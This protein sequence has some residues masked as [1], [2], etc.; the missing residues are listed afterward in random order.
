MDPLTHAV[1][2]ASFALLISKP[3]QK[4]WALLC[5]LIAGTIPDLD[6]LI[7]SKENPLL[8][9]QYHRHFTHSLFF[10]PFGALIASWIVL[11]FARHKIC[12]KE[13]YRYCFI[14]YLT[15]PLLDAATSYGT[16]LLWPFT[17]DRVA[18]SIVPIVDPIPTGLL[19][20]G[21]I[22]GLIS[23]SKKIII[24]CLIGFLMYLGIGSIQKKA[25]ESALQE[26]SS[27]RGHS[28]VKYD[29][30][31]SVLQIVLWRTIYIDKEIIY[32]DA[33]QKYPFRKAVHYSGGSLP[34][35]FYKKES[36]FSVESIAYQDL[37]KFTFFSDDYVAQSAMDHELI[38]D[39]RFALLPHR[40]EPL[41]TV[42]INPALPE[43]HLLFENHR[44]MEENSWEIFG[45][46]IR[47]IPI[48]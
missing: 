16:H 7:R 6:V 25:V 2:G 19:L 44:Q 13:C 20:I 43:K 47:G 18:W 32:V 28:L 5:G 40:T 11:F 31:P 24:F 15:H 8:T 1:T 3:H 17:N 27:S 22:G 36:R 39:I 37:K 23:H 14:A 4:K 34:Q 48:D 41:W 30:K 33:F 29:V 42:R 38:G 46:M 9:I 26:L 35:Y 12:W 45:K 21:S 10:L